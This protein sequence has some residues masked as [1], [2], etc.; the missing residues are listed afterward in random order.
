MP[1]LFRFSWKTV[2]DNLLLGYTVLIFFM[3]WFEPQLELPVGLQV[4]GRTHPLLLHFPI[5]LVLIATILGFLKPA[6]PSSYQRLAWQLSAHLL[7]LT[8]LTGLLLKQQDYEGDTASLHQWWAI[9]TYVAVL[10]VYTLQFLP[11]AFKQALTLL[12][13]AGL[14][15][16]G[17][18]GASLTHGE[19]FITGPL[20]EEPEFKPLDEQDLVFN[21]LIQPV[22]DQKCVTCHRAGKSKG[23]LRLDNLEHFKKGGKSG[24][25][26]QWG[27]STESLLSQRIHLPLSEEEHMPPN[28]KP[29]LTDNELERI[30]L[31]LAAEL[32]WDA[33]LSSLEASHP[34]RLNAVPQEDEN[35]YTFS[36]ATSNT[37]ENLSTFFRRVAPLYPDSPA[38]EVAYYSSTNFDPASLSELKKI[39]PQLV[40]LQLNRMPLAGVDLN[41]LLDF[42]NLEELRLNFTDFDSEQLAILAGIPSLKKLALSGNSLSEA[43][44][45]ELTRLSGL[46]ELYLW[47]PGWEQSQKDKLQDLLPNTVIDFGFDPGEVTYALN[48][49][50]IMV[51]SAIFSSSA[52]VILKHPV[53]GTEIRY[54]LDGQEPDSIGSV[55]YTGPLSISASAEIKARAFAPGW[56]GSPSAESLLFRSGIRPIS[57]TLNFSPNRYYAG[58]GAATL[59]DGV[60][61]A[62]SHISGAWLGYTDDPFDI[63]MQLSPNQTAKELALSILYHEGAYIFPPEQLDI[64]IGTAAGWKK[65]KSPDVPVSKE[66]GPIRFGMIKTALPEE[67]FDRI[68]VRMQPIKRLPKWHP[69]AGAQGWVFIDEILIN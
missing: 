7:A 19:N 34:L 31:W 27:D 11:A 52:Q 65:I 50:E 43:D 20:A 17:H 9:G 69:G 30:E 29:Q 44:L 5:V 23:E 32:P 57:Q 53:Q 55:I 68:R 48:A 22:L 41:V 21:Q 54:T 2:L 42:Q 47:Q 38:L 13:A 49:P 6:V 18:F 58:K 46:K 12:A 24:L 15:G 40:R 8:V 66:T 10:L 16:A 14:I 64:W 59:F 37:I 51:D 67:N 36:P 3:L 26:V 25:L 39:A 1:I 63:E 56:Y 62:P 61:S 60:K 35:K 45:S 28:N 4:V 33:K